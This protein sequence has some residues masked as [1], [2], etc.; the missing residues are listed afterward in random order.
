MKKFKIVIVS[1]LVGLILGAAPI[2]VR[3]QVNND[4]VLGYLIGF[5]QNNTVSGGN[6][7]GGVT[8]GVLGGVNTTGTDTTSGGTVINSSVR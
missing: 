4:V 6:F 5:A 3:A 8:G 7:L 1:V 2:V